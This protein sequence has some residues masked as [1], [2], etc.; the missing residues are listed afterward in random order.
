MYAVKQVYCK[1]VKLHIDKSDHYNGVC[2][3]KKSTR[4]YARLR[5]TVR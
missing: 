1:D 3:T 4:Y 2:R 5:L